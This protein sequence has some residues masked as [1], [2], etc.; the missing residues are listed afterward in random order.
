MHENITRPSWQDGWKEWQNLHLC[1]ANFLTPQ[2]SSWEAGQKTRSV[3]ILAKI[4]TSPIFYFDSLKYC[5]LSYT[6]ILNIIIII[7]IIII[8]IIIIISSCVSYT[9]P[10][11]LHFYV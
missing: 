9:L 3:I 7:I 1:E 5:T 11:H 2:D 4:W 8:K 6:E 10:S